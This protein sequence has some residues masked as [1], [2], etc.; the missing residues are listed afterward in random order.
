MSVLII[1]C[2]KCNNGLRLRDRSKL[3]KKA[4]CPKCW[5]TFIM[6]APAS[7][8]EPVEEDDEDEVE[9][10]LVEAPAKPLVGKA[11]RRIADDEPVRAAPVVTARPGELPGIAD[12][13][14]PTSYTPAGRGKK[15]G[16]GFS[17]P[18]INIPKLS[19]RTMR[20][21]VALGVAIILLG[22]GLFAAMNSTNK[23]KKIAKNDPNAVEEFEEF[24]EEDSSAEP[25]APPAAPKPI[26]TWGLPMGSRAIV[27]LRVADLWQPKSKTEEFRYCLGPLAVWTEGH[28]KKMCRRDLT[29]VE[30]IL[31]GFVPGV[32]GEFPK[33]G[34][35]VRYASDI[36]PSQF[37]N[38]FG[39]K[40]DRSQGYPVYVGD[41]HTFMRKPNDLR[42]VAICP[43][44]ELSV[45]M[46]NG[47][48][49][50][51]P[52]SIGI[53]ALLP[54]TDQN[55]HISVIFE[56]RSI[57]RHEE[58]MFPV[59][60]R[61]FVTRV[62]DWFNDDE[63][64]T[65][66]WSLNLGK[67]KFDSQLAIRNQ[68]GINEQKLGKDM[69]KKLKDLPF[70]LWHAVEKMDP[71][72]AGPRQIIG[73]FPAMTQVFAK[74]TKSS[75]G[76]RLTLMETSLPERAAPNLALGALFAWDE[77]TRTDF[78]K[79]AGT[80]TKGSSGS[81]NLPDLIAD[82]LKKKIDVEFAR[83]PLQE[84]FKYIAE[85]CKCDH[86]IDGDALKFKGYTKN[87]PQTFK[88]QDTG[89]AAIKQIISAYPDM[90]LVIDEKKKM[91]LITTL[92]S[93]KDKG[94]T[95]YEIK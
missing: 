3:G 13:G 70:D 54:K 27:C 45:A 10:E 71:K 83:T 58:A 7:M 66:V 62:L 60:T 89:F 92:P 69:Q 30:Q 38:D 43:N 44:G 20:S 94:L 23:P 84:A 74:S 85:E 42:T 31:I 19:R 40:E 48:Q 15:R 18:K 50:A 80:G 33:M 36:A 21:I 12:A 11:A 53:D 57:R 63:I 39:G 28:L 76:P 90:C 16:K 26:D 67:D 25:A 17:L 79:G 1:H 37:I 78:S 52:Q 64:E 95:P 86:D 8:S 35:V 91:F 55:R 75:V 77:S 4:G 87:M 82:R 49:S 32:V 34:V 46:A 93:T 14:P 22:G 5:H 88:L 81:D 2:P 73:R 65:V 68:T 41:T 59:E 56:P 29:Q 51:N 47:A 6:H 72:V 61:D 9:F 24:E